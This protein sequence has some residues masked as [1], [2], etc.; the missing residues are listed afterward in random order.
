MHGTAGNA[1][2]FP[3]QLMHF[4]VRNTHHHIESSTSTD[5]ASRVIH[6]INK[7]R[8][9]SAPSAEMRD[10]ILFAFK[11][12]SY[13]IRTRDELLIRPEGSHMVPLA[14]NSYARSM[15]KADTRGLEDKAV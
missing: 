4:P 13:A 2:P 9:S 3:G 14:G 12:G 8:R 11:T 6:K 15:G 10:T 5:G 7:Q 1:L